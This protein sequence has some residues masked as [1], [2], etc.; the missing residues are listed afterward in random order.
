VRAAVTRLSAALEDLPVETLALILALGMV[1]GTFPV[2]GCPTFF[3]A[4]AALVLRLNIPALQLV[5]QLASPLQLALLAPLTRVGS[6]MVSTPAGSGIASKLGA[7]A[8]AATAGWGSIC[9]PLGIALYFVLLHG[10]RRAR[11]Q[12]FPLLEAAA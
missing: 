3:C 12:R 9:V 8:L 2:F 10:L 4:V 11:R 5:N 1:L 7:A 6:R